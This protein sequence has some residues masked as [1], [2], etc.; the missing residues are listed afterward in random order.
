MKKTLFLMLAI[1]ATLVAACQPDQ[2]QNQNK[3]AT[4]NKNGTSTSNRNET[5]LAPPVSMTCR[6]VQIWVHDSQTTPGNYVID[7]PGDVT[8]SIGLKQKV[9][10]CI[11][12]DGKDQSNRPDEIQFNSFTS[13]VA[14]SPLDDGTMDPVDDYHIPAAQFNDNCIVACHSPKPSVVLGNYKYSI[15]AWKA[16]VVKGQLDPRVIINT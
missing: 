8:L 4:A 15:K 2:N 7:D 3:N 10:W 5:T 13:G 6:T 11:V 16:G 1:V 9:N 14:T 12:Y